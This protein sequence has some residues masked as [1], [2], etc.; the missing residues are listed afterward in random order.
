LGGLLKDGGQKLDFFRFSGL[1]MDGVQ[2]FGHPPNRKQPAGVF[3]RFSPPHKSWRAETPYPVTFRV[4][5]G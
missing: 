2:K 5:R 4:V 1:S 3:E